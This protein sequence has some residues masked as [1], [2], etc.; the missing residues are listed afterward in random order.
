MARVIE[1]QGVLYLALP[2]VTSGESMTDT[3]CHRVALAMDPSVVVYP[4]HEDAPE[5]IVGAFEAR[6]RQLLEAGHRQETAEWQTR[7]LEDHG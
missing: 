1:D 2:L 7:R 4:L 5:T 3:D 6:V